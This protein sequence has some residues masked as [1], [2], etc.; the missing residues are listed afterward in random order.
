MM[1]NEQHAILAAEL[2]L[3]AYDGMSYEQIRAA[4]NAQTSVSVA[5]PVPQGTVAD[6]P[7]LD[8]V[9]STVATHDLAGLKDFIEK[10]PAATLRLPDDID[11][12]ATGDL[13]GI[14]AQLLLASMYLNEAALTALQTLLTRTKPDPSWQETYQTVLP[15]RA[16]ELGLPYV[17]L[18]DVQAAKNL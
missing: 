11:K 15:S 17:T 12:A 7:T 3:P 8:E 18:E 5:N 4:C 9:Q 6:M 10:V 16:S 2:A 1:T 13:R 14:Q